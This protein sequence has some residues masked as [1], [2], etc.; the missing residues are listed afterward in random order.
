MTLPKCAR[1]GQ[2]RTPTQ[3]VAGRCQPCRRKHTCSAHPAGSPA[4]YTHHGCRCQPCRA[5]ANRAKK[6]YALRSPLVD[7]NP[8]KQHIAALEAAGRSRAWIGGRLDRSNTY[9]DYLADTARRTHPETVARVLAITLHTPG[10]R[11]DP[12]GTKRRIQALAAIG[13]PTAWVA[14]DLGWTRGAVHHILT[15]RFVMG[16]TAATIDAVFERL[17]DTPPDDQGDRNR[18]ATI[19]KTIAWAQRNRWPGPDAWDDIDDPAAKP[20]TLTRQ[21]KSAELAAEVRLMLGT[22]SAQG[23]AKRLGFTSHDSLAQTLARTD[24]ALAHQ[25]RATKEVA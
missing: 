3:L 17:R 16:E 22:D 6:G 19:T 2:P 23:I 1:C 15:N 12:T 21:H 25:L 10:G 8:A 18:R 9:V 24:K 20:R 13:W 4:C 5:A 14:D 11:L 7:A